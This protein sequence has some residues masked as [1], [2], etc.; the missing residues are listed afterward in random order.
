MKLETEL[1]VHNYI[2]I[3]VHEILNVII[4]LIIYILY[5]YS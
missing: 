3:S 4:Q 1:P 2:D 5:V